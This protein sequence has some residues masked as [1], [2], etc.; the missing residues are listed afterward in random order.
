VRYEI[1]TYPGTQHGFNNDTTPRYDAAAA[2][3]AWKRTIDFLKKNL[4]G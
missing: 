3:L 2:G 4:A 1:H